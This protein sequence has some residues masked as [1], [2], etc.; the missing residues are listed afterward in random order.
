[1][2]HLQLSNT[3]QA[4]LGGFFLLLSSF[5]FA[6]EAPMNSLANPDAIRILLSPQVE[7]VLVSQMM[8]N[9]AELNASLGAE[10]TK[11]QTLITFNC[12]EANARL[13]IAQAEY[14]S[15]KE[16]MAV[17][18]NLR[19][20]DAAGEYE[21][22]IARAELRRAEST[23]ALN[24]AKMEHCV[25][26]APF[27][28]RIVKV[29]VKPFQ[30]INSGQILLEI[31]S[32]GP[33]KIRLNVPSKLLSQVQLGSVFSID[34]NETRQSYEAKITAINGR[35]DAVSHSVE[36]EGRLNKVVED[37]LPGMSG[38]ARFDQ[39]LEESL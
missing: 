10:V 13:Q 17:K 29:H 2:F 39:F 38:V 28:G 19:Q 6:E 35:V 15:A 4:L 22:A 27:S 32:R 14:D 8:G 3:C 20:L 30:G 18:N 31:V 21:V 11:G 36:M 34:V 9:I 37:L 16:N 12:S 25:V 1:M 33:L 7:T 5:T 24:Q 23:V 26:K